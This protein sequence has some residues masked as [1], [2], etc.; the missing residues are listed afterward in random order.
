MFIQVRPRLGPRSPP[1]SKVDNDIY[2]CPSSRNIFGE[3]AL[4]LCAYDKIAGDRY[5]SCL[6][7]AV[8]PSDANIGVWTIAFHL[9]LAT[10]ILFH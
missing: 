10:C 4:L 1:A 7:F 9:F 5:F 6:R 3:A 2:P 8:G